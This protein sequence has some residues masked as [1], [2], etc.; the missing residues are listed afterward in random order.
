[1]DFAGIIKRAWRI[2]WQYKVLWVLGIFAGASGGFGGWGTSS[3][4]TSSRD[5]GNWSSFDTAWSK[6]STW[7]QDWAPVLIAAAVALFL[8]AILWLVLSFA[9]QGGLAWEVDAVERGQRASLGEGWNV[10]F[11]NWG[12][13]I[14]AGIVLMLPILLVGLFVGGISVAALVPAYRVT[15]SGLTG[16]DA[17]SATAG[18]AGLAAIGVVAVPV[19]IVLGFVLGNMYLLCVRF[20][21]IEGRTSMEAVRAS[22]DVV[23]HRFKDVLLMWLITIALSFAFAIAVAIPLGIAAVGVALTAVAGAWPVSVLLGLVLIAAGIV[24]SG[25]WST[26]TS[27]MWTIFFRRLTGRE[28]PAAHAVLPGYPAPA[29][30][31]GYYYPP[32]SYPPPP[33][34]AAPGGYPPG[35][36][37]PVAPPAA[38][39]P[40]AETPAP[41]AAPAPP[42]PAAEPSTPAPPAPGPSSEPEVR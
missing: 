2:T 22:W 39:W 32:G 6:A 8:I 9:A 29:A 27:A 17:A 12:R 33:P 14:L 28:V 41:A 21:A 13:V 1:M 37:P 11:H 42:A 24:V 19:L 5:L 40:G 34:P 26:F 10:G 35:S 31:P 4:R 23:R 18:L 20:I 16:L 38:P 30:Q 3:Y 15:S 36:Y 7:M 25:I